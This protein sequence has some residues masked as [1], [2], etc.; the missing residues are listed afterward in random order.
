MEKR[1]NKEKGITYSNLIN[2]IIDNFVNIKELQ[3]FFKSL[4]T[5]HISNLLSYAYYYYKYNND[6]NKQI[7]EN[8]IKSLLKENYEKM[9]KNNQE[10]IKKWN[11]IE[12]IMEKIISLINYNN[13]FISEKQCIEYCEKCNYKKN[14]NNSNRSNKFYYSS[15]HTED[16]INN[17]NKII[18]TEF[19]NNNE[20][21]DTCKKCG[22]NKFLYKTQLISI[23]QI[24]IIILLGNDDKKK[25]VYPLS[26]FNIQYFDQ[27]KNKIQIGTYTLKSIIVENNHSF[28]SYCFRNY[29]EQRKIEK[30][31]EYDNPIILFYQRPIIPELD[32]KNENKNDMI[33]DSMQNNMNK[34]N[35]N[36]MNNNNKLNNNN[37]INNNIGNNMIMN[38]NPYDSI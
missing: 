33:N 31:N 1:K 35:N 38:N 36:N 30:S 12:I 19:F 27:G 13:L 3:P 23:P 26:D 11:Y 20:F 28:K 8:E 4:E 32:Y 29:D 37:G 24:Y 9:K 5:N 18:L 7:L 25:V 2:C 21:Y 16:R 34:I 14:D 22:H 6:E 15:F 10:E 17:N